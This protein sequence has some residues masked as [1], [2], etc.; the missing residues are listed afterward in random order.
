M[1]GYPD[2]LDELLSEIAFNSIVI[3]P[4][5]EMELKYQTDL[6]D[7]QFTFVTESDFFSEALFFQRPPYTHPK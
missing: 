4:Q 5:R 2:T 7:E 6:L 1:G 3:C